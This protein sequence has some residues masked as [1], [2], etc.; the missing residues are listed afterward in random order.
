[1]S[2]QELLDMIIQERTQMLFEK[3][4]CSDQESKDAALKTIEQA[5]NIMKQ[6]SKTDRDILEQY[7]NQ[8]MADMAKEETCLYTNGFTDGIRAMKFINQL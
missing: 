8:I 3:L 7:I 4:K 5:E 2:E 6:L 1:M